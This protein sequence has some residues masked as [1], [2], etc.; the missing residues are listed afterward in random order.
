MTYQQN[1]RLL[2]SMNVGGSFIAIAYNSDQEP[3][4]VGNLGIAREQQTGL[5]TGKSLSSVSES[6]AYNTFGELESKS[7]NGFGGEAYQRVTWANYTK[8]TTW[9]TER[10]FVLHLRSGRPSFA[11]R[12]KRHL[13]K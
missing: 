5:L 4:A 10:V 6:F 9:R 1:G 12:S 11:R 7:L 13:C 3:N 8:T 2:E